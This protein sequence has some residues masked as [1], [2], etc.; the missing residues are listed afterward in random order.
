MLSLTEASLPNLSYSDLDLEVREV[1]VLRIYNIFMISSSE[2]EIY[3]S[4]TNAIR[5]ACFIA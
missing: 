5:R 3:S 1:Q 4:S 2:T